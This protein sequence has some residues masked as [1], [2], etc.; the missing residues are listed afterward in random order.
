MGLDLDLGVLDSSR[1]LIHSFFRSSRFGGKRKAG[2][3]T[4]LFPLSK[5]IKEQGV[6]FAIVVVKSH[7]LNSSHSADEA[8]RSFQYLFPGIPA[9]GRELLESNPCKRI[10]PKLVKLFYSNSGAFAWSAASKIF[11]SSR[12]SLARANSSLIIASSSI[13]VSCVSFNI[14]SWFSPAFRET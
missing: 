5:I 3:C 12:S 9:V 7:V 6:T 2:L 13:T 1:F 14:R 4:R 11:S 10:R 8:R